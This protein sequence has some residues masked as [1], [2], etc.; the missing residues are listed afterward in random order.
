MWEVEHAVHK[1]R[2]NGDQLDDAIEGSEEVTAVYQQ[3]QK[4][5]LQAGS[6]EWKSAISKATHIIL[7][8]RPKDPTTQNQGGD[9][10]YKEEHSF[11]PTFERCDRAS[12]GTAGRPA[13][14]PWA[15]IPVPDRPGDEH[16]SERLRPQNENMML[17]NQAI[18]EHRRFLAGNEE[19]LCDFNDYFNV[20]NEG[21][22]VISGCLRLLVREDNLDQLT[23]MLRAH[24]YMGIEV[25]IIM[26]LGRFSLLRKLVIFMGIFLT[27]FFASWL[28]QC[29][30]RDSP[31]QR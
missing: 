8:L 26:L 14:L 1:M 23:M 21:E 17:I 7:L 5:G 19:D 4:G 29:Y 16:I 10:R 31:H 12:V 30:L 20:L 18:D 9:E 13:S 15:H 22:Q 24:L 25:E 11:R 3:T 27:K 28:Y 6:S 2:T